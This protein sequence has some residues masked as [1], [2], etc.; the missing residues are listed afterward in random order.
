MTFFYALLAALVVGLISF[1]G[2]IALSLRVERLR[3]VSFI[4]VALAVGALLGETFIHIIPEIFSTN[5]TGIDGLVSSLLIIL[6][7]LIF[8]ML[9]RFLHWHHHGHDETEHEKHPADNVRALGKMVLV[10]DSLH[11]FLDGIVLGVAFLVSVEVGIAT[12][13]AIIFHEIP[14]EIGDFGVLLHAG[15]SKTQALFYNFLSALTSIVG[16]SLVFVFGQYIDNFSAY[17]LPVAAGMF[18][19]LATSDLV[20]EL[21]KEKGFLA[22]TLEVLAMTVGVVA[23]Y[24]VT[25]LE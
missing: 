10:S 21:A 2:L 7:I 16:V 13:I 23:M 9:E 4:F 19:Y 25:F 22:V 11:N 17:T 24:L 1:V 12:T 5:D 14:Q 8:F 20:P 15:Y 18:L 3:K 6:G